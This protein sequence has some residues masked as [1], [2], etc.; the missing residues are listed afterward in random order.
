[1]TMRDQELE[2]VKELMNRETRHRLHSIRVFRDVRVPSG[3]LGAMLSVD[4]YRPDTEVQVPAVVTLLPYR[5]D[6][7]ADRPDAVWFAE[8]G[9]ASL[10]VD[11]RGTGS[12]EGS[13]RSPFDNEEADDAV[14][15]IEWAAG[16][17]WCSGRIG[18]WGGSYGAVSA[19]RAASRRPR[20]LEA[21]VALE[22]FLDPERDFVHPGGIRGGIG[23]LGAWGIGNLH[24]QVTPP[25]GDFH[26]ATAR[27]A[28]LDRAGASEPYVVDMV[29]H[30]PGDPEWRGRVIDASQIT[31]PSLVIGGW[32]DVFCDGTVRAFEAIAGPKKLVMGPW[33]HLL[34]DLSSKEPVGVL[35]MALAWWRKWL[36]DEPVDI[37]E[38]ADVQLY[39]QG[40]DPQWR[41]FDDW[42]SD[43]PTVLVDSSEADVTVTGNLADG[44]TEPRDAD[45]PGVYESDATGGPLS[46]LWGIPFGDVPTL[47]QHDDDARS[48]AV[49]SAPLTA[50]VILVGRPEVVLELLDP[51]TALERLAI[52]LSIVAPD[53]T[54]TFVCGGAAIPDRS[55]EQSRMTLWPTAY[56][57]AAGQRLRVVVSDA[58]F[59]R[60]WPAEARSRFALRRVILRAPILSMDD[61]EQIE[62][63]GPAVLSG[64][65]AFEGLWQ[66]PTW[67]IARQPLTE[68]VRVSV[69]SRGVLLSTAGGWF[70]ESRQE[71]AAE[72]RRSDPAAATMSSTAE[73]RYRLKTGEVIQVRTSTRMTAGTVCARAE[74]KA[75][76]EVVLAKEWYV[77][78]VSGAAPVPELHGPDGNHEPPR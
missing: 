15:A 6:L 18:M 14:A 32:S 71:S 40:H 37:M 7:A 2:R 60:L 64:V 1:M 43:A 42:R 19:L 63:P 16:Q 8:R 5:K 20:P 54:S 3:E 53:G 48:V 31:V 59:P 30:G 39:I 66:E 75:D 51:A 68:A 24:L 17:A 77:S 50:D 46:G 22:G 26:C 67:E 34:P 36:L 47:N 11:M 70:C 9:V 52:R 41:G 49:T 21:I 44:S 29:R 72:V 73:S 76:D 35:E 74:V 10:I 69:G 56:R 13:L 62:M 38:S 33:T 45:V 78:R 25:I 61:G 65:E 58:D 4:L 12:S 23:S 55:E 57:I 27:R 28:W